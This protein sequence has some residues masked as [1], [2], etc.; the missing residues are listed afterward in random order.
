MSSAARASFGSR[1]VKAVSTPRVP[2]RLRRR[3]GAPSEAGRQAIQALLRDV[4]RADGAI[5]VGVEKESP[6]DMLRNL[7]ERTDRNRRLVIPWLDAARPLDGLTVLEIGCGTGCGTIPLAEQGAKVM[8]VDLRDDS[9]QVAR[10]RLEAQNLSAEL[11]CL[12]ADEIASFLGRKPFDMVLFWASL[13]HMTVKERLAAL[14]DGW[15]LLHGGGLL[16]LID[17]PNRLWD[18]DAHGSLLPFFHWLP[19]DVALPFAVESPRPSCRTIAERND[20]IVLCRYGGSM[21]FHEFSLAITPAESLD[22]ASGL[23]E[24][25]RRRNFARRI[26]WLVSRDRR[27]RNLLR[28]RCPQI[29]RAFFEENLQLLIRKP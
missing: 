2:L 13:E 9:L 20:E 6:D 21:S 16:G 29:H 12:N 22:V 18:F 5:D 8:G 15:D 14:R 3:F 1:L 11:L 17:T 27:Y 25:L 24:F 19:M 23:D 26:R 10:A 4:W 28:R 7:E